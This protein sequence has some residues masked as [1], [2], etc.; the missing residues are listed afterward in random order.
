MFPF[1][2]DGSVGSKYYIFFYSDG[3]SDSG[4]EEDK[5]PRKIDTP[6][7]SQDDKVTRSVGIL[8]H[9]T[10]SLIRTSWHFLNK[11]GDASRYPQD[12]TSNSIENLNCIF[13][14]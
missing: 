4:V 14:I 10:Y 8:F 3:S 13:K 11:G 5:S 2:I 12:F 9:S 7:K 1:L 6:K